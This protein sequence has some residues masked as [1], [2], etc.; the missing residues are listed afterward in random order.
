MS[1]AKH[2]SFAFASLFPTGFFSS[3]IKENFQFFL[4]VQPKPES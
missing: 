2:I 4:Q 1:N 3:F